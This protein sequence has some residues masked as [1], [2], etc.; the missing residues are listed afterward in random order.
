MNGSCS[1]KLPS[2]LSKLGGPW[3]LHMRCR[4]YN[5]NYLIN[6]ECQ[7]DLR[8]GLKSDDRVWAPGQHRSEHNCLNSKDSASILSVKKL[9]YDHF[10]MCKPA[11]CYKITCLS[12][13]V[14]ISHPKQF[15]TRNI[16]K[17]FCT[18]MLAFSI[19]TTGRGK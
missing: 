14:I 13:L 10:L 4:D 2:P 1:Q 7:P 16:W 18:W 17:A 15:L 12:V 8:Q 19:A 6:V 3:A 5:T 9:L 11:H